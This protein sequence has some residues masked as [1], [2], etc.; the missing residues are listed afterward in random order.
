SET[1]PLYMTVQGRA[2][3][4]VEGTADALA[5]GGHDAGA[6]VADAEKGLSAACLHANVQASAQG[7]KLH[8][9][10]NEVVDY[11]LE[12]LC[13]AERARRK[14]IGDDP[15]LLSLDAEPVP[16]EHALHEFIQAHGFA[17]EW[18]AQVLPGTE[19][20]QVLDLVLQQQA[21][22]AQDVGHLA[23]TFAERAHG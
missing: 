17:L 18:R 8:G 22:L 3:S 4:L 15:K 11:H 16:V 9:V 10:G 14:D 19:A 6:I 2:A 1:R 13:I 7:R 20:E 5:L 12:M 21:V 23:L